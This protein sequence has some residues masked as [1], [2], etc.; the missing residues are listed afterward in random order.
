MTTLP[1]EVNPTEDASPPPE[2]D[3]RTKSTTDSTS[4]DTA[5]PEKRTK[6]LR[7]IVH[8][9]G[10]LY[11]NGLSEAARTAME[12]ISLSPSFLAA[13]R[14]AS[15]VD[16]S[17]IANMQ[18]VGLSPG[19][20]AA[21]KKAGQ[22]DMSA[23]ANM[24][25]VGLSPSLLA[26][27][28]AASQVDMSAVA[29]MQQ[30]GLSPSLLAALKKAGQVDISAITNSY[31]LL[32][33]SA[34]SDWSEALNRTLG[35]SKAPK[36]RRRRTAAQF[37][38]SF[39]TE[40]RSVPELLRALQ[41]LQAKNSY[42]GLVWRGQQKADW[43]VDSS[44]TRR[45]RDEGKELGEEAMIAVELIQ[46]DAAHQWGVPLAGDLNFLAEL[47]HEGVPTRLVDVSLDPEVAV[48]FAVQESDDHEEDD[49]RLFAWG[50]SAAPKRGQ[51]ATEP[52]IIPPATSDAFWQSWGDREI[53]QSN[54][55]GTGTAVPSWQPA[56]LNE[57][58]R[59]Q[60]AAFLFDAEPIIG[61]DLLSMFNE[62]LDDD[63]RAGEIA[64]ATRI[65]GFPSQHNR[66][67]EPNQAGIVPM[68]TLRIKADSKREIRAY[69]EQKGI[70]E[71]TIYPDRA[72]LVTFLHRT[73]AR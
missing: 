46:M 72:G 18:Q 27:I 68:F 63:W 4:A 5:A 56:A 2:V 55:W 61:P 25:Q 40:V 60:R 16:M 50:K 30:V 22:V 57:R 10:E 51:K 38:A 47:Q 49:G 70:S 62:V 54:L 28:K 1:D 59:A 31:G 41:V 15:Q 52:T 29:N 33:Q 36:V 19:L 35:P 20:L 65:V 37:F 64:E 53:R 66:R 24:Q 7:E 69:L 8:D 17:A 11:S 48:W 34:L 45:L 71:S 32:G 67:A 73:S 12:G 44:L 14:A 39:E 23:V 21:L 58:M 13:I 26:A 3:K 42:L 43:S 6:G 9:S